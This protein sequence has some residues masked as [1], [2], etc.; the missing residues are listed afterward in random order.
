MKQYKIP[1]RLKKR[2]NDSIM[3]F[4]LSSIPEGIDLDKW[5]YIYRTHG[6]VLYEGEKP[7]FINRPKD[8]RKIKNNE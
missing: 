3:L 5:Y 7:Q 8:V 6:L 4:N 1:R 2:I